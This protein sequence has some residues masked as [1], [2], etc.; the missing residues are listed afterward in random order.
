VAFARPYVVQADVQTWFHDPAIYA[1]IVRELDRGI[2]R[3]IG[4]FHIFGRDADSEGFARFVHLAA[5]RDLWLHAHCDDYVIERIFALDPGAKVI[6]A[7][8]GMGTPPERIEELFAR[9]PALYGELSYRSGITEGDSVSPAWR[10]LFTKYPQRFLLG[11]DTW[12]P[13]RWPDVPAIM[14]SYRTW[15]SQLPLQ[16]AE[17]IAWRNGFRLFLGE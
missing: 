17:S 15:L 11:S 6:W 3:G 4:E 1:M 16:V 7:H 14:Q 5:Q 9:Y 10:A 12:V 13:H 2:Y 8:T